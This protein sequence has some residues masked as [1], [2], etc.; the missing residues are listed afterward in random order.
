MTPVELRAE[1]LMRIV[2]LQETVLPDVLSLVQQ[3]RDRS[4]E[5]ADLEKFIRN[6]VEEDRE[7]LKRLAQ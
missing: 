3:I 5:K 7:L 4:L 2:Q 6:S 1:I